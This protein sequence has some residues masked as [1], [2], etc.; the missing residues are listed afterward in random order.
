M[1]QDIEVWL[2]PDD[3][4]DTTATTKVDIRWMLN[5]LVHNIE[6]ILNFGKTYAV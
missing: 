4:I 2:H 3:D 1:W 6:K 5:C